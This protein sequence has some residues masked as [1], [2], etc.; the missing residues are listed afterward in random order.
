MPHPSF[1]ISVRCHFR[2]WLWT[3]GVYDFLQVGYNTA[4]SL[5]RCSAKLLSLDLSGCRNL[6]DEALGLIVDSCLSLKVLK[7]FGCTQ[8][9]IRDRTIS[10]M[11]LML[12]CLVL[13]NKI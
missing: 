9:G 12:F 3:N 2:Y 5:A 6:P 8:V 10:L 1:C 11:L 4:V 7:L 13:P